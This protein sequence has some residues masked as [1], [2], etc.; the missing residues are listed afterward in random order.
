MTAFSSLLV[1]LDGSLVAARSLDCAAWLAQRL[2]ARLHV[3]TATSAEQSPHDELR[4]L[5]VAE[6]HWPKIELHQTS[7]SPEK[8]IVDASA[9]YGVSLVVMNARGESSDRAE[10]RE[11]E[12]ILGHVARFVVERCTVPVFLIPPRYQEVLPWKRLVVPVSGAIVC[13]DALSVAAQLAFALGLTVKVVHVA[14]PSAA[15]EGLDAR[16]RYSDALHHEYRGQLD[17]LVKRALPLL[18]AKERRCI[19]GV[20]LASGD[21]LG[22]L[23]DFISGEHG[24][25]VI[26]GWHGTLASGHAELLKELI[27]QITSP[28][29]FVRGM[30][31]RLSRLN[32][33]EAVD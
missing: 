32:T 9:R 18:G 16:A 24:S 4:R 11:L 28:L 1:P 31:P 29:L 26:V 3:L 15:D 8:A 21:V 25:A 2:E 6:R 17:E 10:R 27:R 13:D 33:G 20:S 7:D 19:E 22:G 30:A 12:Q 14:S 5:R 23:I